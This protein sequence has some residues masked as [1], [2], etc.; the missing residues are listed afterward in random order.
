MNISAFLII[1]SILMLPGKA[2]A[3]ASGMHS[4]WLSDNEISE[5]HPEEA[6]K[7]DDL[8]S[9]VDEHLVTIPRGAYAIQLGA[10][11]NYRNSERFKKSVEEVLPWMFETKNL[12]IVHE[13]EYY[14]VR[15]FTFRN[16]EEVKEA[17]TVLA[18]HKLIDY[19]LVWLE[20]DQQQ[21]LLQPKQDTVRK[22]AGK[23]GDSS[24][25]SLSPALSPDTA[26]VT[27]ESSGRETLDRI[28]YSLNGDSVNIPL[29]AGDE[30]LFPGFR[31]L[32]T[33][34]TIQQD[35]DG[36]FI[37]SPWLRRFDYFGKSVTLVA[38]L[39]IIIIL[40]VSTMLILLVIILLN[41]RRMER[42][43]KLYQYLLE[44]YQELILSFL[45]GESDIKM[46]NKIASNNYRR[47][48]LI[49][50]MKDVAVNLKGDAWEKLRA[51]YIEL[52]LV[53]DSMKKAHARRWHLKIK[54]FREL[55]FM[56][57]KDANDEIYICLNSRNE[58]LRME[59]QIALVRL[60]DDRPFE[61]LHHMERPFSLWEQISLHEL[62][63]QHSI[64][65]P[66]FNQ[67][68]DSENDTVVMF[69]LRMIKEFR[70]LEA[71]DDVRKSLV[72]PDEEVR[73]LAIRVAGDLKMKSTLPVMKRMYKNEDYANS[74]EILRSMGKMPDEAFLGFLKL[75][76]D[77][78]DDVQLQIEATKAIENMGETG[79]KEL[80]KLMKSEYKNYNIII[81]HVLDR[82]IY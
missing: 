56:N 82:R 75:V 22:K 50:Q 14:K 45:Y 13:D 6:N 11:K 74:L 39:I 78:E 67:W 42:R 65:A 2:V 24:R 20:E 73:N 52:G 27:G 38:A 71:E 8:S 43:E 7:P 33:G 40:S 15:I 61:F 80:V 10:F 9:L 26:I 76:L 68:L 19:Q 32:I 62:I 46:F 4:S 36:S 81:R 17:L 70:Q 77:K 49:D 12:E 64:E 3:K 66:L 48:V 18:S 30:V 63:V 16:R 34:D 37:P 47:Q 31:S 23:K 5:K 55:A 72:H 79:I 21:L 60:S 58:I 29:R 54:G 44:N 57:I 25:P 1:C 41:R 51:L 53:D 28:L 59:A 35:Y 69:A